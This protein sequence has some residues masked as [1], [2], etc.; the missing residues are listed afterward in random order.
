[1][2]R[3]KTAF[4]LQKRPANKKAAEK[5]CDGKKYRYVYYAQFQRSVRELHLGH[6]VVR[7]HGTG[8]RDPVL[9]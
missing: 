5:K 6:R 8:D 3:G 4:S 2:P 9:R 1:M 7:G